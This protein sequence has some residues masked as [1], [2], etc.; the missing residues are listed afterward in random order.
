LNSVIGVCVPDANTGDR[1]RQRM[2]DK[3]RV[4]VSG[5]FGAPI[6]RIGQMGEQCREAHLF[7]TLHALGESARAAGLS[8]SLPQGMAALET[9]L[10]TGA[11]TEAAAC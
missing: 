5:S 2:S 7:R 10:C 6:I 3:D 4:E 8:V 11:E 1:I 9:S